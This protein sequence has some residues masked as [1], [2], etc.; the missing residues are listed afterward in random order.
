MHTQEAALRGEQWDL[1]VLD[2]PKLAP[3]KKSLDRATI[4]YR[5]LN[6]SAMRLVRPG[7]LLVTCSCSGAMTQS[8]EFGEIVKSAADREGR[9]ITQ[10]R[11]GGAAACHTLDPSYPEG[12]YLTNALFRVL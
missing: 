10:L 5:A 6:R 8:G 9:A 11:Y 4:K 7:G 3:S 2:P 1:V 12:Q